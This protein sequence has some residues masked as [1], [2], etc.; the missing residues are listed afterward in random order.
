VSRAQLD[1]AM[2]ARFA[3]PVVT[4]QAVEPLLTPFP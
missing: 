3:S 2:D 1:A 4:G